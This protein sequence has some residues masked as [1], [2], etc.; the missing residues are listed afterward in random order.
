MAKLH[1]SDGKFALIDSVGIAA[2]TL[3]FSSGRPTHALEHRQLQLGDS[4]RLTFAVTQSPSNNRDAQDDASTRKPAQPHQA[5]VLWQAQS[6]DEQAQPGRDYLST[7][8]VRKGGKAKWELEIARA[9]PNILSISRGP[10]SL[11]LLVASPDEPDA[12]KVALGA[13]TIPSS[14]ALPH[15]YPATDKLPKGWEAE[16]YGKMPEIQHTFRPQEK[17]VSSVIALGG[18]LVVLGPWLVFLTILPQLELNTNLLTTNV[19]AFLLTFC[20]FEGLIFLYWTSL[21]LLPTLPYFGLLGLVTAFTGR[22]ALGDVRLRR[23]Q[24]QAEARAAAAAAAASE[25]VRKEGKQE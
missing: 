3:E 11:T 12:I 21:N 22:R 4:L 6:P 2:S 7:V 16:R 1:V 18:T 5:M 20:A 13:V 8:K 23:L 9:S 10:I 14:L 17:R 24:E 19:L 25:L 15:P